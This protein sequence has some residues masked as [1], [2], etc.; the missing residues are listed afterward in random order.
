[1]TVFSYYVGLDLGQ[2][3]DHTALSVI[4]EPVWVPG[5]S[6]DREWRPH[7]NSEPFGNEAG[8]GWVSPSELTPWQTEQALALLWRRGRPHAPGPP[9][10]S[11]RHLERFPLGTRYP[12]VVEKVGQLLSREPLRSRRAVLLVDKTGVGASVVDSFRQAG[13][14]LSAITIHGGSAVSRDWGGYRV[15]KRDLVSAVQVL[16]Q[17]GR[18]KIAPD[19]PEAETLR[20]EL[21]NFR[22]KIDPKTAHDSYEHWREN[23]HDDLVLA[24]AMACWF[25]QWW[26][27]NLD[28]R[29][30]ARNAGLRGYREYSRVERA[31]EKGR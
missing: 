3:K 24:T 19:L 23:D 20:K 10:L 9:P 1:M 26:N 16:L 22:V 2:S 21:L 6:L 11:V 28:R 18:L 30:E 12:V 5:E 7:I 31:L 27:E 15:P 14:R 8:E 17:S 13:I 29:E 25:R 4:E